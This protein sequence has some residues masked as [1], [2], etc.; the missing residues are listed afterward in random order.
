MTDV[1]G[2][3]SKMMDPAA[4]VD[5]YGDALLRFAY[6][7]LNNQALAED[8]V[9]DTFLAAFKA[10]DRFSGKATVKTWLTGILKNKIIDHYR[11]KNRTQSM[12]ELATFYERQEEELF[13]QDGHWNYDNP[14]VPNDWQPEQVKQVNNADFMKQFHQCADKLPKKVR[15]VFIMREVDGYSSEEICEQ[16]ELS[17]ANLWTILHRARM[18]LRTCLEANLYR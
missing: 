9:Q 11:K 12:S 3:K 2:E 18:A 10:K 5:D 17:R 16:L 6:Y 1:K 14:S 13:D 15:Q 7:R 4:W 8:L